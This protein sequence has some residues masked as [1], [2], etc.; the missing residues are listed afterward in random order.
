L[1]IAFIITSN[2]RDKMFFAM[3]I[4]EEKIKSKE[5]AILLIGELSIYRKNRADEKQFLEIYLLKKY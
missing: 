3:K 5:K 4:K 1:P 2:R